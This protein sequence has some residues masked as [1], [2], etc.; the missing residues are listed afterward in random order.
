MN[1]R[2]EFNLEKDL[3]LRE[4]RGVG[5]EEIIQA[6]L[7]DKILADYE[8]PK[9]TKYPNQRILVVRIKNYAYAVPYIEDKKKKTIFLKTAYPS[10]VLTNKYLKKKGQNENK[11]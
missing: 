11:T 3:I 10:R 1:L 7:T 6:I 5:F 9:K 4:T 8:H 2:I